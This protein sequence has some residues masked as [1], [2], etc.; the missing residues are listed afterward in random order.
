VTGLLGPNGAGKS[1]TLRLIL[2]LD[3]PSSGRVVI[4]GRAHRD[5]L[6]DRG[7]VVTDEAGG[8]A[9]SGLD[10]AAIGDLAAAHGLRLHE[11]APRRGT[12]EAAF[13]E[14]TRDSVEYR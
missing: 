8:L 4:D 12:L 9:V 13:M 1:T 10:A 5:L 6:T 14:L 11:L 7:A 3:R 2:G